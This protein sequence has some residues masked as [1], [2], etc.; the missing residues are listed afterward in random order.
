MTQIDLSGNLITYINK[1][2]FNGLT[3]LAVL[4]LEGNQLDGF[5]N[6]I[7]FQFLEKLQSSL[8]ILSLKS[9]GLTSFVLDSKREWSSLT[10]LDL[11]G[12]QL[13]VLDQN[14]FSATPALTELRLN[15]NMLTL[16]ETGRKIELKNLGVLEKLLLFDNAIGDI[17]TQFENLAALKY[18]DLNNNQI[19]SIAAGAF[20]PS[21]TSLQKLGLENNGITAQNQDFDDFISMTYVCFKDNSAIT[22]SNSIYVNNVGFT[23]AS[24][25]CCSGGECVIP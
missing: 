4:D 1:D 7:D 13:T 22:M 15:N 17:T 8:V 11:S 5:V 2:A 20:D 10:T 14:T 23:V 21:K 9:C 6:K 3:Y 24:T 25:T 19:T 12:N 18:L 16:S